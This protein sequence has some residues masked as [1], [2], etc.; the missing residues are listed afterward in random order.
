MNSTLSAP[1]ARLPGGWATDV[2][3]T[4]GA[5]GRIETV[6][7]G[8]PPRSGDTPLTGQAL[9]PAPSNLHSH[10]FQRAMAGRAERRGPGADSFWTWREQMYRFLAVLDPDAVEA[11]AALAQMEMLEAGYGAVA[12]FH[13]LHHQPGGH[14]YADPAELARRVMAAAETTGIGLTLLPVLYSRAGLDGRP[15]EDGQRRF[16]HDLDGFLDLLASLDTAMAAA[17]ADWR[18]GAAPHSLRAVAVDDLVRLTEARPD[19]PLHIHVAEQVREVEDVTEALGAPPVTILLERVGLGPRWCAVHATHMTPVETAALAA[20]G[21]VAGLCPITEANLGDGLFPADAFLK[22][23]GR[24]G[25]GTDSNIR[26]ALWEELR[27]LEYGQRL[28]DRARTVLAERGG[29]T[30]ARLFGAVLAGGAQAL[31]RM[32]GAVAPGHWAD[33]LAVDLDHPA[34]IGLEPETLLDGLLV[35]GDAAQVRAVWSAGRAV[36][37]DGRHIA[38]DAIVERYRATMARLR[39]A[40]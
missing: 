32:S 23:G 5:D 15:L 14:P 25:V 1:L 33:L 12:E 30:G 36:V 16:G 8:A 11:I 6:E 24:I 13:Y 31:D 40:V 34:L 37:R 22:A 35:A 9:L 38:R 20:T 3:V 4:L 2:R 18:L 17:P 27:T 19:G 21:A 7:T 10:A 26:I 29:S 28:R 39:E